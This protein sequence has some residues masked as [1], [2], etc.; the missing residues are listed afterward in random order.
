MVIQCR[1]CLNTKDSAFIRMDS[2][3]A[4]GV[5]I[6]S[7][8]TLCTQLNASL[9]DGLPGVLC[10][11]CSQDLQI[12]FNFVQTAR[13]VDGLLRNTLC[14][15]SMA[16][17]V[18][19]PLETERTDTMEPI[20]DVVD[21][22]VDGCVVEEFIDDEPVLEE[23][24]DD[25]DDESNGIELMEVE[26]SE[27]NICEGSYE[28]LEF[29][30]EKLVGTTIKLE[31]QIHEE[32][33]VPCKEKD[34]YAED[35]ND[36]EYRREYKENEDEPD[37]P[38][39]GSKWKCIECK[40]ILCGDVSYE[41]HMNMHRSLRPYKC[42]FCMC[43]F[44]CKD[45]LEHHNQRRH[46]QENEGECSPS[47]KSC[48]N[49]GESTTNFSC[50]KC[51]KTYETLDEIQEHRYLVHPET[52]PV[53]CRLCPHETPFTRVKLIDHFRNDHPA[54]HRKYFP[55][56]GRP[57][58]EPTKPTQWQ[59]EICNCYV[60]S[61][62][63]LRDHRHTHQNERPHECQ[64]CSK[65]F[66]T[67]SNLRQHM[68][69]VHTEEYEKLISEGGDT[70]VQCDLCKKQLLR[71]N[72]EK[73]LALHVKKDQDAKETQTKFLCAY[74]SRQFSNSKSLSI[75][76]HNVHLIKLEDPKHEC[77]ICERKYFQQR[78]LAAHMQRV[79]LAE[80]KHICN[81]CG[82]AYKS[83]WQLTAHK[84]LHAEEK[85]FQCVHC[86]R[87]Y[88]RQADLSVHMRTHTGELPFACH[89]C[90]KRFAIKVRLTYHLQRH[91]GIKHPCTYCDN[92]YDNRNQLKEHL[93]K[94]TGMPYRCELCPDV[95]FTRRLRFSGHMQRV[96]NKNLSDEELA[97]VFTKYTGKAIH[98][99]SS[100]KSQDS[101]DSQELPDFIIDESKVQ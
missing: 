9:D 2:H 22:E 7:C 47:N 81:V 49:E 69:G 25:D 82:N 19:E 17:E 84:L 35:E 74:C 44:R 11:N 55:T 38:S 52:Y 79:H 23:V 85:S 21:S 27:L 32:L 8:F 50:E 16:G 62:V 10:S 87:R 53:Q 46:R 93:Y 48:E 18:V 3:V 94:H 73:H 92:V 40:L 71:R 90:D 30:D 1:A 78:D 37:N 64:F 95:G 70:I 97:A 36:D 88:I 61:E 15:K 63:A 91:Q 56:V 34:Y 20:L 80:R 83:A 51:T 75:H 41:G 33:D 13:Q 76:E 77:D 54:E 6:Y 101:G 42:T 72:L 100:F 29:I 68:R 24:I 39:K 58:N 59:C 57:I 89:L 12:C 26:K 14:E 86:E 45:V 99:N 31:D 5:D 60:R 4:D 98:F 43:A 28:D 96:H 67:T 66:V 65:R